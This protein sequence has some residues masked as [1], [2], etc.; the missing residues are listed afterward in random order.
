MSYIDSQ[1]VEHDR[2]RLNYYWDFETI[3]PQDRD[4]VHWQDVRNQAAVA[5]MQSILLFKYNNRSDTIDEERVALNS[6]R[7]ADALVNKLK[8]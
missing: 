3:D 2:E 4:D 5:A 6:L 1:G 8:R 7:Y